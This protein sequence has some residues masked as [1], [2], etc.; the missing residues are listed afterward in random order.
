MP[1]FVVS[2]FFVGYNIPHVSVDQRLHEIKEELQTK[3]KAS[4]KEN[5]V[6]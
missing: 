4:R 6:L 1:R 3:F 2:P 5:N